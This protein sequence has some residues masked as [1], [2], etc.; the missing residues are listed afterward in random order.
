MLHICIVNQSAQRLIATKNKNT[1]H[2]SY[3][4]TFVDTPSIQAKPATQKMQPQQARSTADI[5]RAIARKEATQKI[6]MF[7]AILTCIVAAVNL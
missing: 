6:V 1:Q 2:M 5:S 7:I 4:S 3:V